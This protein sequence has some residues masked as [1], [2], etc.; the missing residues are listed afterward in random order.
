MESLIRHLKNDPFLGRLPV[1]VLIRG[2]DQL[3]EAKLTGIIGT[4]VFRPAT[5][6]EIFAKAEM[7]VKVKEPQA[8]E[9][10]ARQAVADRK[11]TRLNS[12]HT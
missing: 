8:V 10:N 9:R 1:I 11:S 3:N 4:P 7:I 5:A 2:D 12:S 6:E